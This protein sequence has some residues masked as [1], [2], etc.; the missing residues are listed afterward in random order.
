MTKL[1][2][3]IKR[4]IDDII[5]AETEISRAKPECYNSFVEDSENVTAVS[6]SGRTM[7]GSR[8]V[9][10]AS[11]TV[12]KGNKGERERFIEW[13][14]CDYTEGMAYVLFK[15]GVTIDKEDGSSEELCWV[16]TLVV[17]NTGNGWKLV[18]RHNTRSKK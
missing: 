16:V 18:H 13:I 2:D 12:S 4:V 10:D 9:R 15:T 8:E 7:K 11:V 3:D 5:I 17:K 6:A 1:P 14:S